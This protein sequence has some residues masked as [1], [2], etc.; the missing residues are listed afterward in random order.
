M[1]KYIK[2]IFLSLCLAFALIGFS[3][4]QAH[5]FDFWEALNT[6]ADLAATTVGELVNAG[7]ALLQGDFAGAAQHIKNIGAAFDQAV[8]DMLA[9]LLNV[10]PYKCEDFSTYVN[11]Y[12]K[13][14]MCNIF[15]LVFDNANKVSGAVSKAVSPSA[16]KALLAFFGMWIAINI[17]QEM[18]N[19]G[20][21]FDGLALATKVGFMAIRVGI[22]YF[23]LLDSCTMVFEYLIAPI[24]DA[25]SGYISLM[26]SSANLGGGGGGAP[27]GGGAKSGMSAMIKGITDNIADEQGLGAALRC[28]AHQYKPFDKL[29]FEI[30]NPIMWTYG[31]IIGGLFW[32]LSFIFPLVLLD[33]VLRIGLLMG[34]LPIMF[35]AA[36]FDSTRSYATKWLTEIVGA[37]AVFVTAAFIVTVITEIAKEMGRISKAYPGGVD[38]WNNI[39]GG[40]FVDAYN[41]MDATATFGGL[42]AL[43]AVC[44]WGILLAPRCDKIAQGYF[45]GTSTESCALRAIKAMISLAI[46]LVIFILTIITVGCG[47]ILYALQGVQRAAET[48]DKVERWRKRIQKMQKIQRTVRQAKNSTQQLKSKVGTLSNMVG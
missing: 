26:G 36:V 31:C 38:F 44:F 8:M 27:L 34:F 30:T 13:C 12:K 29:P 16:A 45:G 41:G 4:K 1:K 10:E 7:D 14:H 18:S 35:L 17:L 39:E 42:F 9:N 32:S 21:G 48:A 6:V 2:K 24:F 11:Q 15:D 46:S 20:A 43:C 37:C 33:V 47:A 28:G 40:K 19:V 3:P 23:I 25:T 5:A 22:A